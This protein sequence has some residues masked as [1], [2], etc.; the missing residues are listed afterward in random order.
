MKAPRFWWTRPPAVIARLLAGIGWIYGWLTAR[1]MEQSGARAVVPV[2]CIGNF[3]V[4]G[5]GKTPT[6]LAVARALQASG[7]TPAFLTRGYRGAHRGG[8]LAVDPAVHKASEVG[9]EALLLARAASTIT[10]VDRVAGAQA[11]TALGASVLI[12]DDGLQNPTLEKDFTIAVVDGSRGSGNG[13]C[14]PAGPLRAPLAAQVGKVDAILVIGL[15]H[16]MAEAAELGKAAGK[17][18]Y[19]T[20]FLVDDAIAQQFGGQKVLAYAGIGNPEKFHQT[21]RGLYAKVVAARSFPDHHAFTDHDAQSLLDE[22]R[23]QGLMLVTTEKDAA[24]LSGSPALEAL[25]AETTVLPV[26]LR[27]PLALIDALV[28]VAG[29]PARTRLS[30]I[31]AEA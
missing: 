27:L 11:A 22:A 8:P 13:L 20:E 26:S 15:G 17:P 18:V 31:S 25:R 23:A 29:P 5:A 24:R 3:V 14:I 6:A 4:G 30:E 28:S 9:D 19:R 21:L 10:A 1:R 16:G 7:Q 12:M 2:I